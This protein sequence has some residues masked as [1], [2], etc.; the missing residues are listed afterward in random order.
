M[1]SDDFTETLKAVLSIDACAASDI[2]MSLFSVDKDI[3]K[4]IFRECGNEKCS[5]HEIRD[6]Q[7]LPCGRCEQVYYCSE[8][9]QSVHWSQGHKVECEIVVTKFSF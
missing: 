2:L 8:K 5:L 6:I 7:F 4:P 1:F 9:C 3:K